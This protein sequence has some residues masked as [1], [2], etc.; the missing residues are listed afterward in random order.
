MIWVRAWPDHPP[1]GRNFVID[2]MQRVPVDGYDYSRL[3][4]VN[5]EGVCLLDWDIAM[6]PEDMMAFEYR[7]ST[8]PSLVRVAPYQLWHMPRRYGEWAVY[9]ENWKPLGQGEWWSCIY[10]GFGVTYLPPGIVSE[11]LATRENKGE[12]LTDCEF[13]TWYKQWRNVPVP[14]EWD[15]RPIHLHY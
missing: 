11:C 1:P 2:K 9:G 8:D 7:A 15:L 3:A 6:S 5:D 10:F 12:A 13:S 14:V 4:E